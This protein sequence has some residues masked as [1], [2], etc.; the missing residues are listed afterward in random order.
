MDFYIFESKADR[1]TWGQMCKDGI[2]PVV[3]K[4]KESRRIHMK[5][6][7]SLQSV[8]R[9]QLQDNGDMERY[10]ASKHAWEKWRDDQLPW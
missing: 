9:Q 7:D 3:L 1:E 2:M 5:Q 10:A 6:L 4:E 8:L